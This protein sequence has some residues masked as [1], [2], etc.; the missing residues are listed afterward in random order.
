MA[1]GSLVGDGGSGGVPRILLFGL[2]WEPMFLLP[3]NVTHGGGE[4][5]RW[6]GGRRTFAFCCFFVFFLLRAA[7]AC[8]RELI[9]FYY[10]LNLEFSGALDFPPCCRNWSTFSGFNYFF[11][12]FLNFESSDPP[13]FPRF[14]P[15]LI[16]LF[17]ISLV[18]PLHFKFWFFRAPRFS[19]FFPEI[20]TLF[21]D[22]TC[23]S[24]VF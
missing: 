17:T 8:V 16:H 1:V 9:C 21:R 20:G 18:F 10:T 12:Y 5:V 3:E 24:Y 22:L 6:R 14:F 2:M 23:F 19:T 13:D 15:K 7:V 11:L 4:G